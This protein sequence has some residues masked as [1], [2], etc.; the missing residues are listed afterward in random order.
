M[1]AF[2]SEIVEFYQNTKTEDR[3]RSSIIKDAMRHSVL[4][5][6]AFLLKEII[7]NSQS[8]KES[9]AE[10]IVNHGL[11]VMEQLLDWGNLELFLINLQNIVQFLGDPTLQKNSAKCLY[12]IIDKGMVP[13]NKLLLIEGINL[14]NILTQWN[15]STQGNDE[16]FQRSVIIITCNNNSY[17]LLQQ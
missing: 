13:K 7:N 11:Q 12:A 6:I 2:D 1:I 14:V 17:R 16:D 15:P 9:K 8:F 3:Q 10:I 4:N 5:D